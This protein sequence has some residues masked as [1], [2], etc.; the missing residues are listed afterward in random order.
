MHTLR[1]VIEEARAA[2][3]AVGHF[4]VS[5]SEQLH[6]VSRAARDLK[7]PVI[8][9]VSEGER[10][11]FGVRQI[12]AMVKSIKEEHEQ[13]IYL[14]A[15]HTYSFERVREAIDAGFDAVIYDGNKVSH[16]ENVR[17]AKECVAYAR[18]VAPGILV[19]AELGNIGMSSKLLDAVP[20]GAQITE[21]SLTKAEELVAFVEET[22][23]DLVAPAVGNLHG[24]LVNAPAPKLSITRIKE[25]A[26]VSKALLV[27]HGGSGISDEQF[28][29]AIDAGVAVIHINTEIRVAYRRGIEEGLKADE[30]EVAPYRFMQRGVDAVYEV[31]KNRLKLFSRL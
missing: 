27:L 6:A 8:I 10:D 28:V 2:H 19:E 9:G 4:N 30:K 25:L 24:M 15:D 3:R 14:N 12:V 7:V 17:I 31:T 22:G 18:Q 21:E 13:P 20:E 16:E 1:E 26:R 23:V 5:D 11:F 29:E